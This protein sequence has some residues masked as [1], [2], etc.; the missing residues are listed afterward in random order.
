MKNLLKKLL[1]LTLSILIVVTSLISLSACNEPD[2]P[3]E[4]DPAGTP[5][6]GQSDPVGSEPGESEPG[7]DVPAGIDLSQYVIVRPYEDTKKETQI[8]VNLRVGLRDVHGLELNIEDGYLEEGATP[9][10]ERREILVGATNRPES[11]EVISTLSKLDFAV[12][13]VGNKIVIAG[14]LADKTAEAVDYF[15]NNCVTKTGET[16]T[17]A[18]NTNYTAQYSYK[19]EELDITIASLNLRTASGPNVNTQSER[20]PLIADFVGTYLPDSIGTQECEIYWRMRLD[21]ALGQKGYARAVETP[22]NRGVTKNY[23]WYNPER[24]SVVEQGVFWLSPTPDVSSKGFG[25]KYYISCCWAMFEVKDTGVRYVHMNTH[26][27]AYT[28]EA[29]DQ[30]V[31]V[32]LSR[33]KK[34]MDEGYVV[35]MTGDFNCTADSNPVKRIF[36]SGFVSSQL[37]APKTELIGTFNSFNYNREYSGPIDFCFINAPATANEFDVVDKWEDKFNEAYIGQM[38]YMSDHNGLFAKLTIYDR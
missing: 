20:E 9:D 7:V 10:P 23:I 11:T 5:T 33:A 22:A 24:L 34:F 35:I 3:A 15:V 37:T 12:K 28:P 16:A 14:T 32:L 1:V 36:E 30:E 6:D 2:D 8:A 27:D 26:F 17:I 21:D 29:R 38:R 31:E 4:S 25:S 13:V 18:E 19:Y